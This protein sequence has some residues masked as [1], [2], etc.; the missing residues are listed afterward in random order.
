[1]TH[2][3]AAALEGYLRAQWHTNTGLVMG[4]DV[5]SAWGELEKALGLDG[6]REV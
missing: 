5:Q 1:L 3:A 2:A 4:Q 6:R